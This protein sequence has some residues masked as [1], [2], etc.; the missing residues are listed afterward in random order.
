[1]CYVEQLQ[2]I[3]TLDFIMFCASV[4]SQESTARDTVS[5]L[6][7]AH[8]TFTG[9]KTSQW[10]IPDLVGTH[11]TLKRQGFLDYIL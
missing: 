2:L 10:I 3:N 7:R 8:G 9:T 1:M 4:Y 5:L 11:S 6:F